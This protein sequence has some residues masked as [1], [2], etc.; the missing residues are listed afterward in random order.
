MK[1]FRLHII[2]LLII[3]GL[4]LINFHAVGYTKHKSDWCDGFYEEFRKGL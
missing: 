4:Q 2:Y 1:K 3:A